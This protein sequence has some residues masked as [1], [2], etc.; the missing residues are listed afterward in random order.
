MTAKFSLN[1]VKLDVLEVGTEMR[2]RN[3]RCKC[4]CSQT[5]IWLELSNIIT[6]L[7][8]PTRRVGGTKPE[9]LVP[10]AL[11]VGFLRGV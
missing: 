3:R 1:L 5:K 8:N 6:P 2:H 4:K 7:K 11:R 10:P 9:A